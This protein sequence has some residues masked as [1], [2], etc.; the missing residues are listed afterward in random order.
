VCVEPQVIT[1]PPIDFQTEVG[2]IVTNIEAYG[3]GY[4]HPALSQ[5]LRNPPNAHPIEHAQ[6]LLIEQREAAGL[7]YR[8][9]LDF[10]IGADYDADQRGPAPALATRF[11]WVIMELTRFRGHVILREG[12]VHH[13]EVQTAVSGGVSP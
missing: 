4:F 13:V 10:A 8:Y 12:G 11:L 5:P 1:P 6:R 9:L 2:S 7:A 3:H